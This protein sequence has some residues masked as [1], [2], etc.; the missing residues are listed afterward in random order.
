MISPERFRELLLD[1][2]YDLLDEPDAQAVREYLSAHPE[3][4]AEVE[5]VRHL[6]A[7][8]ARC[9]FP[10]V[11]F[12]PP[13]GE[14]ASRPAAAPRAAAAKPESV[15][16]NWVRWAVAA[17]L[18]L[19]LAA[20]VPPAA[21][22]VIGY[23]EH[24]E[25]VAV[26]LAAQ[27]AAHQRLEEFAAAR[28]ND[29]QTA[30]KNVEESTKALAELNERVVKDWQEAEKEAAAKQ[31]ILTVT[32]PPAIQPG[33]PNR[34][35][36][37]TFNKAQAQGAAH[38]AALLNIQLCDQ[39]KNVVWEEKEVHSQG[40]H[41]VVFP[42]D[43]AFKGDAQL[44]FEVSAVA[45]S[46]PRAH[47]TERLSWSA[48][49]YVAYLATDKPMYQPGQHVWFR[50]LAL[51]RAN[52]QPPDE[53]FQIMFSISAPSGAVI[54]SQTGET[55]LLAPQ[56]GDRQARILLGPDQKPVRGVGVGDFALS[57]SVEGGEYTLSV[58]ELNN[59]FPEEK[60][61]FLVNRY[62]PDRLNKE[63]EFTK[64][65]YGPGE[66]A[67]AVCKASLAEGGPLV[68]ATPA[69]TAQVDGVPIPAQAL[70]RTD[71]TGA[72]RVRATLPKQMDKGKSSLSVLFTDGGNQETILRPIPIVLKK[73]FL[74]YFPEGGD[75]IA[76]VP[77]RVY[78]QVKTTQDKPGQL[79]ARIVDGSG[80]TVATTETLHDDLEPGA[81]QGMGLFTFTPKVGEKYAFEIDEPVGV[82]AQGKFPEV[83]PDGI[84]MSVP[85]GVTRPGDP[86]R[87]LL[88]T[89]GKPREVLVG[90][91]SRGRL[92][93]HKRVRVAPDQPTAVELT[94]DDGAGG[95][96]RVTAFEEKGSDANRLEF[97]PRAERLVFRRSS[98]KIQLNVQP[99]KSRYA[100]G[101]PVSLTVS[102]TDETG[103]PARA[104]LSLSVVNQTVITMADIKTDRAMTTHFALVG[105]VRKPED[106]EH[107][108]FLL[109]ETHPKAAEAL[110]LLLGVQGW[111]RFAEQNP[112][113]FRRNNAAEAER[114]L[115]LNGQSGQQ[116]Q[117]TLFARQQEIIRAYEP[118]RKDLTEQARV[119]VEDKAAVE[120]KYS[121]FATEW[122]QYRNVESAAEGEYRAAAA[123]LA[124]YQETH[125]KLRLWL[126][127]SLAGV[128]LTVALVSLLVALVRGVAKAMPYY[129]TA[130]A[131]LAAGALLVVGIVSLN[132]A[133]L[134][135]TGA[136]STL[137]AQ[138]TAPESR[139][140]LAIEVDKA[141]K[142]AE[143]PAMDKP[144]EKE[145][146]RPEGLERQLPRGGGKPREFAPKAAAAPVPPGMAPPAGMPADLA[147]A[148]RPLAEAKGEGA[149]NEKADEFMLKRKEQLEQNLNL[150]FA[151]PDMGAPPKQAAVRDGAE[152]RKKKLEEAK[153]ANAA[154]RN[155]N[156]AVR[157][158]GGAGLEDQVRM[159]AAGGMAA[160]PGQFAPGMPG[161]PGAD[162]DMRA[163]PG[164][165]AVAAD[166]ELRAGL[167]A[168]G[169]PGAPGMGG[170]GAFPGGGFGPG[171]PAAFGGRGF[172]PG[173]GGLG[174]P[175][176]GKPLDGR[177]TQ[178]GFW[179]G[180]PADPFVVR[181]FRHE[182]EL[183]KLN[184]E[185]QD[186]TE[187]TVLWNPVV[188]LP[189]DGKTTVK[190]SVAD[191]ITRYRVLV[192]GHT[193]DGR[194]GSM[195]SHIEV[196]KP[197]SVEAKLPVEVTAGDKLDIPVI[198]VNDTDGERA[199]TI[200][201]APTGFELRSGPAQESLILKPN[202]RSRRVFHL[203]PALIEGVAAIK[204]DGKSE[205][206]AQ[207]GKG[208]S[209]P[210]VPDGFPVNG[211]VSDLLEKV[212]EHSLE[213]PEGYVKGT[214]KLNAQ[215]Y[216]TTLADLQKGLEGLLREP[217]GCFEQTSTTNY[218]NT[219]ILQYL[220]ES[221]QNNPQAVQRA[222]DLLE[223]GYKRLTSFECQKTS[224]DGREGYEW[225]GGMAPPHEALTA[226]GLLQFKDMAQVSAVDEEM[227]KRTRQYLL[228]RRTPNGGFERNSRALDTFGRAPQHITDAYIVWALTETGKEDLSKEI[229]KLLREHK[230][231]KDPYFLSLLANS[232][233]N[234]DRPNEALELLKKVRD[235]QAADGALDAAETSITHSGGR[236]LRIETTA[237][238]VLAWL[239]ANQPK[240]F[241]VCVDKAVRWL[242]QQRGGHGGFGSTQSTILALKALIAHTKANKKTAEGG[243]LKLYV[244]GKLAGFADF[245]PDTQ[246]AITVNLKN[247]DE[248]LKPGKNDLKLTLNTQRSYP[249]TVGWSYQT[250]TPNS[251]PNC[252]VK[253]T[254]SLN[255]TQVREGDTV[256]LTT[257]VENVGGKGQ[258]QPMTVAVIGLPAGLKVPED[259]KQLK[260]LAAL[261]KT[262]PNGE[263]EAG[264]ISYFEIRGRE[265]VLYWRDLKPDAKIEVNLDLIANIPGQYRGPASRVYLYYNADPKCWVKPLEIAIEAS[266]AE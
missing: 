131:S 232:L 127:P 39:D 23:E 238:A 72:V 263:L 94:P 203:Q 130:A 164:G 163:I 188:V 57:D 154:V 223:R 236:E 155:G 123:G 178:F 169:R 235:K 206:L 237:L 241:T 215:I 40:T 88:H 95:V 43:L 251:D 170:G 244:N 213:L 180:P 109:N 220:K 231:S 75:L 185:R 196:R 256:R 36:V 156:A 118:K 7:A 233:L 4:Q 37:E 135:G 190:F 224:N 260:E 207:D 165:G 174:M 179:Q 5:R 100:P 83:K 252:A 16:R 110:D 50:M 200:S 101:E 82:K 159:K 216:P 112:E 234:R 106:L 84:A 87:V 122:Q 265:L 250:V 229:D 111:R 21:R 66:V 51:N 18:I 103:K 258:G 133:Q 25:Q 248:W 53:D 246:D 115:V 171:G 230:D 58:R 221:G 152:D 86:I 247:A 73:L 255:K 2:L 34:F 52:L 137:T 80:Q 242:G 264:E 148:G 253:L 259:M 48:P 125:R 114:V 49:R 161:K 249:F 93:E 217:Y 120:R 81:N 187:E 266:A 85:T 126:L 175:G 46:G 208:L 63:L 204:I 142:N 74:E 222:S 98:K 15:R 226:Y 138:A 219:L 240:E 136:K 151:R 168:M 173:E 214:L 12:V 54:W 129:A 20:L 6:V 166:R 61:K 30:Q 96:V 102:A 211:A 205:P 32:G 189:E 202:Q 28:A 47:V 193:L 134:P 24:K 257:V 59:R 182:V 140:G 33:A 191:A 27:Q 209:I 228:N 225:F 91:Y 177:G 183:T 158:R 132:E 99:D 107:A 149:P 22:H 144:V 181:E 198:V 45:E 167:E 64:S 119:A 218:P 162:K 68:G 124:P 227:V 78:Y 77:N 113:E 97:V 19:G 44:H 201:V 26:A 121:N 192:D 194:L 55:R 9:E 262:G 76:G 65:S 69:V 71:A 79:K 14:A 90:A 60:R 1:H 184:E 29:L 150:R 261:R 108:D 105:E 254:T 143:A 13:A 243:T 11:R 42:P 141:D 239:K 212:A 195:K 160:P 139:T 8:A 89:A 70:G 3:A 17:C 145:H 197:F 104:I 92:L 67:E 146:L 210:V 176:G 35:Q 186:K 38:A 116:A 31:L 147:K 172:G 245:A 117:N 153:D 10:Q 41:T 62:T 128:A 157:R 56:A 199:A